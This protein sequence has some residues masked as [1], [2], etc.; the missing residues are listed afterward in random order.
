MT[1]GAT[2]WHYRRQPV[3]KIITVILEVLKYSILIYSFTKAREQGSMMWCT[4]LQRSYCSLPSPRMHWARCVRY[5][6]ACELLL[7]MGTKLWSSSLNSFSNFLHERKQ[8]LITDAIEG[9]VQNK[10]FLKSA[11]LHTWWNH[12]LWYS[13]LQVL[14]AGSYS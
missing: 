4:H 8:T 11:V 12:I 6:S 5:G 7:R 10:N 3:G 2:A 1:G 9:D 13:L 14:I